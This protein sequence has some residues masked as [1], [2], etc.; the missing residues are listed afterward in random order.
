MSTPAPNQLSFLPDDYLEL[1]SQRRTNAMCAVLFAVVAMGVGTAFYLTERMV[2]K[3]EGEYTEVLRKY[4]DA[5][6]PIDQFKKM[7]TQQQKMESQAALSA[8]LLEKVPRSYL[9]AEITNSL[10]QN[11]SLIDFGL[12]CKIRNSPPAPKAAT[13]IYEQNLQ[14][15]EKEKHL[16]APLP[17]PRQYDV[18]LK[19]TG[20]A[21]NDQQV[22]AFM[23]ALAASSLLRD[24]NL[25]VSDEYQP[26]PTEPKIRKF[27]IEMTLNPDAEVKGPAKKLNK[28]LVNAE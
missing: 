9:L 26:V 8:S 24:V 23:K 19:L 4:S 10:P 2:N 17:Q 7:Q 16:V 22:A 25:V 21:D 18:S 5:A 15:I 27:Q 11:V 14:A 12:E 28:T 13:T 3:V 20:M 6:K 1:K